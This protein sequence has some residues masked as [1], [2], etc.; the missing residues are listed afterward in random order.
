MISLSMHLSVN[1]PLKDDAVGSKE[2][3]NFPYLCGKIIMLE[4]AGAHK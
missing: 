4:R 2:N 1:K 3:H